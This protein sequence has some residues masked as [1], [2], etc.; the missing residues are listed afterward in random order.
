M[1]RSLLSDGERWQVVTDRQAAELV[2][3]HYIVPCSA[4]CGRR[5]DGHMRE[6]D[7]VYHMIDT[8]STVDEFLRRFQ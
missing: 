4:T 5:D 3:L 2:K 8:W 6:G 7:A 1:S